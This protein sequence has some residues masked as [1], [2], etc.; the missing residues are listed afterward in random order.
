MYPRVFLFTQLL[1]TI[2]VIP[3]KSVL[4]VKSLALCRSHTIQ[5]RLARA[6]SCFL[7]PSPRFHNAI[8]SHT[9]RSFNTSQ[10][11]GIW[12]SYQECV[13]IFPSASRWALPTP[14]TYLDARWFQRFVWEKSSIFV[15]NFTLLCFNVYNM[16]KRQP[17]F[18]RHGPDTT[19]YVWTFC[20]GP[21]PSFNQV[22]IPPLVHTWLP[23]SPVIPNH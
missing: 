9:R 14:S 18:V 13:A 17:C 20:F 23:C 2:R 4:F 8:F 11:C 19:P 10:G 22:R 1:R 12:T 16:E 7:T 6:A 21:R 5:I 15:E 3:F